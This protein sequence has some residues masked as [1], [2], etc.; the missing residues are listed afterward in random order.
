MTEDPRG[1]DEGR[2][3]EKETVTVDFPI[4]GP[5]AGEISEM[6]GAEEVVNDKSQVEDVVSSKIPLFETLK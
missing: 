5:K 1:I 3:E 4:A 6:M 2:G